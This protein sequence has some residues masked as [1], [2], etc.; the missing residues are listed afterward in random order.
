[1]SHSGCQH[2]RNQVADVIAR[3]FGAIVFEI[4]CSEN[5]LPSGNKSGGRNQSHEARHGC[6]VRTKFPGRGRGNRS[7][8]PC[9]RQ[10]WRSAY[11][12]A[13]CA[14]HRRLPTKREVRSALEA[15]GVGYARSKDQDGKWADLFV[16]AGL[17]DL[18]DYPPTKAHKH[19][20]REVEIFSP[21][22]TCKNAT[23]RRT[24]GLR[25]LINSASPKNQLL[26]GE[27]LAVAVCCPCEDSNPS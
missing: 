19:K 16:R 23:F 24:S 27:F 10:C 14:K 9:R 22:E 18:P 2:F 13:L 3:E 6:L 25:R 17:G 5:P 1:M 21:R 11:A 7:Y 8:D 12:R 20:L 26:W 15:I 4:S